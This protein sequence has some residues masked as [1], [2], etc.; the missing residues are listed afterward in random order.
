MNL[1]ELPD[2]LRDAFYVTVGLGV[3]AGQNLQARGETL[4]ADLDERLTA[5][6]EQVQANVPTVTLPRVTLPAVTRR[7]G[8]PVL[9]LAS[10]DVADF[11]LD[12]ITGAIERVSD[13]LDERTQ[14]LDERFAALEARVDDV[15]DRLEGRLPEAAREVMSQARGV[16]KEARGTLR[17]MVTRAA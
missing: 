5:L 16:A 11:D 15:L 12:T 2:H 17:T 8:R 3:L 4:R 6:R 13:R 14:Q 1:S 9:D 10:F 7:D